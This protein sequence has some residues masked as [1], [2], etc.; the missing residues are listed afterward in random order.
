[1]LRCVLTKFASSPLWRGIQTEKLSV[2]GSIVSV[3]KK[4]LKGRREELQNTNNWFM[5]I[6]NSS[7]FSLLNRLSCPA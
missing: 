5:S 1:M 7:A 6:V 4:R 2:A 3:V